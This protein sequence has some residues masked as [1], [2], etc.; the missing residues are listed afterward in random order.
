MI[1]NINLRYK[2]KFKKEIVKM[3]RKKV[4][5]LLLSAAMVLALVAAFPGLQTARA[6]GFAPS[7]V[8][9][10][11]AKPQPQNNLFNGTAA[12]SL[13]RMTGDRVQETSGWYA[14]AGRSG[15]IARSY[16][17]PK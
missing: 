14:T 2:R 8:A 13:S 10:V 15:L 12:H 4:L 9:P 3:M 7:S 6:N 17:Y 11:T 16:P 5:S 1:N